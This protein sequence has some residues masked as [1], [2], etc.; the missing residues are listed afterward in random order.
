[1]IKRLGNEIAEAEARKTGC[2]AEAQQ[3]QDVGSRMEKL[4]QAGSASQIRSAEAQA[5]RR[6]Q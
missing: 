2:L 4:V 3:R 6:R 1:M 5:V